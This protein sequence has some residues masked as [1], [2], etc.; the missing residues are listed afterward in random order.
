[1]GGE[2]GLF[3]KEMGV[4]VVIVLKQPI[5]EELQELQW[6]WEAE[7]QASKLLGLHMG[8]DISP[9]QMEEKTLAALEAR[10]QK[11]RL[12]PHSLYTRVKIVN[13]LV[14]SGLWYVL[15]LWTGRLD[16]LERFD[17]IVKDFVW[18]GQDKDKRSRV[19][20]LTL[21]KDLEEGGLALVSIK[22]QTIALLG[23]L[24]LWAL[25]DDD[26]TL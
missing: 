7:G 8:G 5:P 16:T 24:L 11:A 9:V 1:M 18:S 2:T 26:H 4:K 17:N 6:N 23:K 21:L 12:K 3:V 20:F 15:Q 22:G 19:D 25:Q 13:Q 14:N 10:L